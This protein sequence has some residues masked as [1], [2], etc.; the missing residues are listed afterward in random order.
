MT[1]TGNFLYASAERISLISLIRLTN[2]MGKA[3]EDG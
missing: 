1:T 2:T 3:E